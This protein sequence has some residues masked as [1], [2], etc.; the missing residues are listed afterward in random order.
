MG[1][2]WGY[3]EKFDRPLYDGLYNVLELIRHSAWSAMSLSCSLA[4]M[5]ARTDDSFVILDE[6][7]IPLRA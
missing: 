6:A 1:F 2:T 3:S 5:R 7:Q 4:Y